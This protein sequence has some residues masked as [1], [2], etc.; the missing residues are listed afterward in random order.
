[1]QQE[2]FQFD[3]R[4]LDLFDSSDRLSAK[5]VLA[6]DFVAF[7]LVPPLQVPRLGSAEWRERE[8]SRLREIEAA[9]AAKGSEQA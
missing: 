7:S 5:A 2:M 9:M 6:K 8:A 3:A 4:G 1:M